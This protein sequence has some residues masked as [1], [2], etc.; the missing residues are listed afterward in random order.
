MFRS[1]NLNHVFLIPSV[2]AIGI[3]TAESG[4]L[5][6]ACYAVRCVLVG[7]CGCLFGCMGCWRFVCVLKIYV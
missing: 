4:P 5:E 3:D 7:G 2:V 6:V 1:K